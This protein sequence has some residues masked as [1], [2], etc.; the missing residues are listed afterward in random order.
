MIEAVY[1]GSALLRVPVIVS[2]HVFALDSAEFFYSPAGGFSFCAE[3]Q[4]A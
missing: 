1:K 2:L 3:R 4:A